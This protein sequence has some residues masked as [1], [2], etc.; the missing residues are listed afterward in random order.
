[1]TP[2]RPLAGTGCAE[3]HTASFLLFC[4]LAMKY[5]EAELNKLNQLDVTL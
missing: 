5:T 1:M 2:G 3:E 4:T